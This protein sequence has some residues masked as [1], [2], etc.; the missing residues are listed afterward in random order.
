MVLPSTQL[1]YVWGSGR[2]PGACSRAGLVPRG[3]PCAGW[4]YILREPRLELRKQDRSP[5]ASEHLGGCTHCTPPHPP[6]PKRI[7]V[8]IREYTNNGSD[9]GDTRGQG[10]QSR[11]MR[12]CQLAITRAIVSALGPPLPPLR[13]AWRTRSSRLWAD[14]A[15]PRFAATSRHRSGRAL[16][17]STT[18]LDF[19][20]GFPSRL[21][22]SRPGETS[23]ADT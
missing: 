6:H 16:R 13:R 22:K 17:T 7:G 4:V 2:D 15:A 18:K 14:G 12:A 1:D 3:C 9:A 5:K 19:K 11:P 23:L 10:G 20:S 8:G 21:R